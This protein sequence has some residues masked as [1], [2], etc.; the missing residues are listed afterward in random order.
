[1]NIK[2]LSKNIIFLY[3]R[4]LVLLIVMFY[5]SRVLLQELGIDDYGL[6][7]VVGGIVLLFA[8]LKTIFSSAIQRFINYEK[9]NS[10]IGRIQEIFSIGVY[11]HLIVSILFFIIVEIA[12]LWYIGNKLV[13]SPDRISAAYWVLH[14]SV[15][16]SIVMIMT[17]PYD[18]LIIANE[19]MD[20]FAYASILDGVL[21]LIIV[22]CLFTLDFDKLKLYSVLVFLVSLIMRGVNMLY[23]KKHFP[24]CKL[25]KVGDK[26]MVKNMA[27]FA[28][29]NFIGN[30]AYSISHEGINIL[31][32][33]FWGTTVNAARGIVY[34]IKNA[35]TTIMRNIVVAV[36]PQ[37]ISLYAESKKNEFLYLLDLYTR[38]VAFIY[39]MMALPLFLYA[40]DIIKLWLG[41]LPMHVVEFLRI[42]LLY[43]LF[44]ALHYPLDLVFKASGNLKKYQ[45]YETIALLLTVILSYI[46]L[47]NGGTMEVPFGIMLLVEAINYFNILYL[48]GKNDDFNLSRYV[49]TTLSIILV[50][51]IITVGESYLL[52]NLFRD[53]NFIFHI[54]LQLLVMACTILIWGLNKSEKHK[55]LNLVARKR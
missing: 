14:F 50:I 34:Q 25:V 19:K 55:L 40:D 28:A 13:V 15:L 44:R 11:I 33:M 4:M 41:I 5:T 17:I 20:F 53:M 32:N 37:G 9:A 30:L 3:V 29:W 8:S 54:L 22:F 43:M 2:R 46:S 51:I 49:K 35:L 39:I 21:R 24:E 38:V 23:C 7:N 42:I 52:Q 45:L 1:M 31:L 6:Y 36:N 26:K 27:S 12:G 18:A 48:A 47:K 10:S 16:S